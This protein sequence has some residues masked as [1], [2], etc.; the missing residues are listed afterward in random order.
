MLNLAAVKGSALA[1][2]P[3][4]EILENMNRSG[5]N[6][7]LIL[8]NTITGVVTLGELAPHSGKFG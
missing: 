1:C 2:K 8:R 7:M 6:P 3:I 5:M 4:E